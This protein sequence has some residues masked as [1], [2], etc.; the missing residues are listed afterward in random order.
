M[1]AEDELLEQ[2]HHA[3]AHVAKLQLRDALAA[4]AGARSTTMQGILSGCGSA[5]LM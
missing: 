4:L 1:M 2:V 3:L 5:G